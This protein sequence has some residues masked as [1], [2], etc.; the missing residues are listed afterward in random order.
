MSYLD[1]KDLID[2]ASSRGYDH[3]AH[4][5]AIKD[6]ASCGCGGS[7]DITLTHPIN[8]LTEEEAE[9]MFRVPVT[10]EEVEAL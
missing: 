4:L 7:D 9:T 3:D 2:L 1:K 6:D 5:K 10:E 8:W